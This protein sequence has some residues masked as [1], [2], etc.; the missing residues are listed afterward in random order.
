MNKLKD[1]LNKIPF[2]VSPHIIIIAVLIVIIIFS[3]A[4]RRSIDTTLNAYIEAYTSRDAEAI[5]KLM[6]KE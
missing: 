1:I 4:G 6:P 5:V 2:K 3:L